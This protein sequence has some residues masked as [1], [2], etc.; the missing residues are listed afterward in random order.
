M[1]RIP[2]V[3]GRGYTFVDDQ[4]AEPAAR[5]KWQLHPNGYA[6][7]V[8][9]RKRKRTTIYLHRLI[10]GAPADLLVD[11]INGNK[12][13]NRRENL[14]LV[15]GS[16]NQHNLHSAQANSKTGVLNVYWDRSRN[17]Y[18]LSLVVEGRKVCQTVHAT[19][20]EA[21]RAAKVARAQLL[22]H[23]VEAAGREEAQP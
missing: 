23:S 21:E 2:L 22:S 13:D 18:R 19:L 20:E 3:S 5:H 7:V 16:Q 6:S 4:D 12:L 14:R 10:L 17:R 9:S 11:H 15:N 1:M 8:I